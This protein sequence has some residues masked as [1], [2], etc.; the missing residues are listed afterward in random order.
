MSNSLK[1]L[2]SSNAVF[3]VAESMLIPLYAIFAEELGASFVTIGYLAATAVAARIGGLIIVRY[4]DNGQFS[5]RYYLI[6][7]FLLRGIAWA[8]LIFASTLPVLFIIQIII[9]LGAAVGSPGFLA[10]FAEHLDEEERIKGS[11]NWG[12]IEGIAGTIGTASAGYIVTYLGFDA[13]FALM[14]SGA[15]LASFVFYA[16]TAK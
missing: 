1:A 6:G 5:S 10:F 8:G 13:L 16:Y 3:M 9:G 2:Y 7:G 12:I 11:A 14:A 4:F 15:V